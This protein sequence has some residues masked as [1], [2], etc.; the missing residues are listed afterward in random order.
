MPNDY[1]E[2]LIIRDPAEASGVQKG[3]MSNNKCKIMGYG[4]CYCILRSSTAYKSGLD[5]MHNILE[6][7]HF[8]FF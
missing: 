6:F 8:L 5:M 4:T 2:Q 3:H 7:L 1:E